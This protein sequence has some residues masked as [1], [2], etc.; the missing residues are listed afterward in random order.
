MLLQWTLPPGWLDRQSVWSL[1]CPAPTFFSNVSLLCAASAMPSPVSPACCSLPHHS[2]LVR[3]SLGA[4]TW[5]EK[6][7][8][9]QYG[10]LLFIKSPAREARARGA[11]C[12]ATLGTRLSASG[13]VT[14][15]HASDR[16]RRDNE[17]SAVIQHGSFLQRRMILLSG[18]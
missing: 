5:T 6:T 8:T 18:L 14:C 4:V 16:L 3:L 9:H 13:H 7:E 2:A 17:V 1:R 12:A 11:M 10:A 15:A